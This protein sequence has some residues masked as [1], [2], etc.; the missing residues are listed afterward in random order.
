MLIF[1]VN[2]AQ[3]IFTCSKLAIEKIEKNVKYV[4]VFIVNFEHIT[5]FGS[6]TI[7]DFEQVIVAGKPER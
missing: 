6:F 3:I 2:N 4:H 7:A 5:R 1:N